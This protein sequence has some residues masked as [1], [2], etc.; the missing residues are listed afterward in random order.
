MC[1]WWGPPPTSDGGDGDSNIEGS[2][3]VILM[4]DKE[5]KKM[6]PL[7]PGLVTPARVEQLWD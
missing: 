1:T 3:D 7:L 6:M 2:G 5:H 4:Y